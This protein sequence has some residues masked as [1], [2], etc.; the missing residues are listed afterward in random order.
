MKIKRLTL[1]NFMLFHSLDLEPSSG[2]NVICGDNSTGKTAI[3]KTLYAA[4]QSYFKLSSDTSKE[5]MEQRFAEKLQG[6]FRPDQDSVG[7]LVSRQRGSNRA[8]I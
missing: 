5:N 3:L 1:D 7:R 8:S 2:V 4:L 6:V